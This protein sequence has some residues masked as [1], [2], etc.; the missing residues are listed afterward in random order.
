MAPHD[1]YLLQAFWS[2]LLAAFSTYCVAWTATWLVQFFGHRDTVFSWPWSA[3]LAPV[4]VPKGAEVREPGDPSLAF[5]CGGEQPPLCGSPLD[6]EAEVTATEHVANHALGDVGT[7]TPVLDCNCNGMS[8]V[9]ADSHKLAGG[10][11]RR[12]QG[13]IGNDSA[14]IADACT[15]AACSSQSASDTLVGKASSLLVASDSSGDVELDVLA[16]LEAV[17]LEIKGED[18]LFALHAALVC[19]HRRL[20]IGLPLDVLLRGARL[21]PAEESE[22]APPADAGARDLR[23]GQCWRDEV[24]LSSPDVPNVDTEL[25]DG[26]VVGEFSQPVSIVK[27]WRHRW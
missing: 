5:D 2:D 4:F 12:R 16:V 17:E 24:L 25:H 15:S 18:Q 10:G 1:D 13:R 20:A 3:R 8:A 27:R 22:Q 6:G 11:Q 19:E 23:H 21:E 14:E 7:E 26:D 9:D